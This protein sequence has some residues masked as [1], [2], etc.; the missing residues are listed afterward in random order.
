MHLT[1]TTNDG[2][3]EALIE[4]LQ[5][6]SGQPDPTVQGIVQSLLKFQGIEVTESGGGATHG[7]GALSVDMADLGE[8]ISRVSA[9]VSACLKRVG[10]QES[11]SATGTGVGP[12]VPRESLMVRLGSRL[13]SR[14]SSGGEAKAQGGEVAIQFGEGGAAGG[15]LFLS[16]D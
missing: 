7:H 10:M 13:A 9:T 5:Q 3:I 4:L 11:D 8:C 16:S 6:A 12:A 14:V 1:E 15:G 2:S